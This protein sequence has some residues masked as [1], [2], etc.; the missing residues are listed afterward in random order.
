MSSQ[1]KKEYDVGSVSTGGD[2]EKMCWLPID[3]I[4]EYDIRPVFIKEMLRNLP[5]N[6]VHIVNDKRNS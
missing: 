2:A 6:F 4:E 1:E 5:Q 3:R